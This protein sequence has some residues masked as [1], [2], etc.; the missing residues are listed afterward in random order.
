MLADSPLI[1]LAVRLFEL[2]IA[3]LRGATA[4]SLATGIGLTTLVVLCV[5][6]LLLHEWRRPTREPRGLC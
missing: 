3:V 5:G 1:D 6:H 2:Q 4:V